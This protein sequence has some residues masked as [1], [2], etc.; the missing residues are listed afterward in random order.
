MRQSKKGIRILL[1][2]V[3][4]LVCGFLIIETSAVL[5][6]GLQGFFAS[7]GLAEATGQED[8]ESEA[9][10]TVA[11]SK[12][13]VRQT[14]IAPGQTKYLNTTLLSAKV[15]GR[16]SN[17]LVRP[18]DIV[19][20]GDVIAELDL[21]PLEAALKAARLEQQ[22]AEE[23]YQHGLLMADQ[24]L[25]IA[26]VRLQAAIKEHERRLTEAELVVTMAQLRLDQARLN[27][28]M[29]T[30]AKVRLDNAIESEQAAA[31]EYQEAV[32]RRDANWEPPELAARYLQ[33][34]QAAED[35]RAI[36]EADYNAVLNSQAA[37]TALV[38]GLEVE[39]QLAQIA[40]DVLQQGVDP[41]LEM[42]VQNLQAVLD[43][44]LEAGIDQR[45]QLAIEQAIVDLEVATMR[46]PYD[47]LI[48][49][50]RV[51]E[52]KT[53]MPGEAL[54]LI[55][56]PTIMEVATTVIEED[57]PLLEIGQRAEL[58]IDAF[59]D[60]ILQGRVTHINPQRLPSQD[61]P[62][63]LVSI[64]LGE[65]LPGL[66]SGMTAD[67]TVIIQERQEVLRLPRALTQAGASEITTVRTWDGAAVA[68]REIR[69]GMRGDVYIEIL[70]GLR[71]GDQVVGK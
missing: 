30:A 50:V 47:S 12:G 24:A 63:Y 17:I 21:A 67:A 29:I 49:E 45:F 37:N 51:R 66:A 65:L 35:V 16:I 40:L 23:D 39:V 19:R 4:V 52:G 42:E 25:Q 53:V 6:D 68:E 59:P 32:E 48:L 61:R 1:G 20:H 64:Q 5:P 60:T 33:A 56:D 54:F 11:V 41:L 27:Y 13:S 58:F 8:P 71:E 55:A 36:A 10:H 31:R 43:G 18:G 70:E 3:I 28:P 7:I 9:P 22:R 14:V 62:L 38:E 46:S 57:L 15:G 2:V 44:L 34:L 26:R 69:L